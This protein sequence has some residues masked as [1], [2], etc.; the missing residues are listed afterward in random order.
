MVLTLIDLHEFDYTETAQALNIPL[1]TVKSRLVRARLQ[2][3]Q[4]L[5]GYANFQMPSRSFQ[6]LSSGSGCE[7]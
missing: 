1:G 3:K 5:K 4:K 2:M 6:S 7:I